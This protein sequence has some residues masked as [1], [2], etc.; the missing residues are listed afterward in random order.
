[1][2][3]HQFFSHIRKT[4][5]EYIKLVSTRDGKLAPYGKRI[6]TDNFLI[7]LN[8]LIHGV[9]QYCYQYGA[10]KPQK[11]LLHPE[12]KPKQPKLLDVLE[13]ITNRI[14]NLVSFVNPKKRLLIGIDGPAPLCKLYQQRSR[15]MKAAFDNK[16]CPFQ[17]SNISPGTKFLSD[18]SSFLDH[19]IQKKI[20]DGTWGDIEIIFSNCFCPGEA[21]HTLFS[22]VREY[23]TDTESYLI[24]AADA[25][26]FQ[27]ALASHKTN[28]SILRDSMQDPCEYF[29]VD[30]KEIRQSLVC[31]MLEDLPIYPEKQ[32]INDYVLICYLCGNDFL[33]KIPCLS[34]R[35][36]SI[37]KM[38][39]IYSEVVKIYGPLTTTNNRLNEKSLKVF[40]STLA[41]KEEEYLVSKKPMF[42]DK[43]VDKYKK[44]DGS[45]DFK[46]YRKEYY[47]TKV[48]CGSN[49]ESIK[50]VCLE[51]LTGLQQVLSYYLEGPSNWRWYYPF[52]Y[53]PLLT[54][55]SRYIDNY[56][57]V[58]FLKTKPLLP[59]MQLLCI[60]NKESANLLPPVLGKILL[61]SEPY[62]LQIDV[63]GKDHEYEGV[64]VGLPPINLEELEKKYKEALPTLTEE[65]QRR[66]IVGKVFVYKKKNDKFFLKSRFGN[67]PDCCV[68]KTPLK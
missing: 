65:E 21:E 48:K 43:L 6:D 42:P 22:Y 68:S 50:N 33:S 17:T 24:T 40:L 38:F 30:I 27:L 34:I 62:E 66:N 15:R 13:E 20:T 5:P 7:D 37:E 67:I 29:Y 32:H 26:L 45:F 12:R 3:I 53:S 59:F 54:D 1:M 52:E 10:Y 41:L 47:E 8:G 58:K 9:T 4:F 36:G 35:E 55:I 44:D 61:E 25:D 39:S 2:G 56:E 63:D 49:E 14:D 18:V 46:N 31:S 28:F 51:Y 19:H 57:Y 23:G 11:S 60:L 16:D 64:V